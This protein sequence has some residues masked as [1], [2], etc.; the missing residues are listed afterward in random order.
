MESMAKKLSEMTNLTERER[1]KY[2]T[3]HHQ[4]RGY[5]NVNQGFKVFEP[6]KARASLPG[7]VTD[8]GSGNGN[9]AVKLS[10]F[11]Y[12][13]VIPVDI[14]A[15]ARSMTLPNAVNMCLWDS[16][17]PV[18]DYGFC[19]DV[20]EHIPPEKVD[21]VLKNISE[22]CRKGAFIQICFVLDVTGP[23]TIGEHLHLTVQPKT[24]WEGKLKEH[25]KNVET[26]PDQKGA[27]GWFWCTNT[28]ASEPKKKTLTLK[29]KN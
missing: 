18:V 29:K 8:I 7:S 22:S 20:L 27:Q 4:S 24:W 17:L 15:N 10:E 5:Q 6:F 25:F 23:A 3:V 19:T 21:S 2:E 26:Q 13:P 16:D 9:A 28:V 1:L 14:A 11:G 12:S